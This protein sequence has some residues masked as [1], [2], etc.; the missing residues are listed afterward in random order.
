MEAPFTQSAWFFHAEG[1]EDYIRGRADVSSA[2]DDWDAV[3]TAASTCL[4]VSKARQAARVPASVHV[5]FRPRVV[6][7]QL[8]CLFHVGGMEDASPAAENE[9]QATGRA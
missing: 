2:R 5:L 7:L 6:F 4:R 1:T 3:M 9:E 8:T